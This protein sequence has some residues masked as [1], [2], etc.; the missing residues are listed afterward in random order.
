MHVNAAAGVDFAGPIGR[1]LR[2]DGNQFLNGWARSA[3][4]E[5]EIAAWFATKSADEEKT[6]AHRLNKACLDHILFAPLG[7]FLRHYA[8]RK[9]VSGIV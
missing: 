8:W 5:A 2:A 9:N 3:Q 1:L 4:V 6:I 7:V